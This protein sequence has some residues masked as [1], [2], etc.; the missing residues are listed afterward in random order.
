MTRRCFALAAVAL[1]L[2]GPARAADAPVGAAVADAAA[3]AATAA[4][5]EKALAA[6]EKATR[7]VVSLQADYV[8]E[9][10]VYGRQ[11]TAT[12]EGRFW[13][14]RSPQGVVSARWEGRD[15]KGAVLRLLRGRELA[16]WRGTKREEKVD[17]D[18]PTVHHE[19]KFGFPLLPLSWRASCL[20]GPPWTSPEWDDRLPK[21][22]V[23]GIPYGVTF[24]PRD[25]R[26][27]TFKALSFLFDEK[28][29]LAYRFRCDTHG[30]QLVIADLDNVKVNPEIPDTLFEP[31]AGAGDPPKE[32][33]AAGAPPARPPS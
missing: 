32:K 18:D 21:R 25:P 29:A 9:S 13:W 1:A 8:R 20:A 4:Q 15:E 28:T 17:L 16:A 6:V 12:E 10:T 33:P 30:W 19:A 26:D 23:D 14:K 3:D 11:S 2:I 7:D 27:H 5:L 24:R 22:L 31:P